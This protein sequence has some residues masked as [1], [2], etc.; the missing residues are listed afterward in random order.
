[1]IKLLWRLLELFDDNR[2]Y[3]TQLCKRFT[4]GELCRVSDL[5]SNE[6][7]LKRNDVVK[8]VETSRHDYLVQK[9][10]SPGPKQ[11]QFTFEGKYI[12]YQFELREI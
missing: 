5:I 8:I 1:M 6:S 12:V 2:G 3:S 9:M 10:V 4:V 11:E 7:E